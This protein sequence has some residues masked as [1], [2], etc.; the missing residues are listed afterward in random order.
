MVLSIYQS[1]R[2][3]KSGGIIFK[4]TQLPIRG[5]E[6]WSHESSQKKVWSQERQ[7]LASLREKIEG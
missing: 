7:L 5:G 2:A 4:T 3:R 1:Y 6:V